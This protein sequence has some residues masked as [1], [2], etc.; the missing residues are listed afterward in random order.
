M[1]I[2][3]CWSLSEI[4]STLTPFI[5]RALNILRANAWR[6]PRLNL[7][8]DEFG[9]SVPPGFFV[10]LIQTPNGTSPHVQNKLTMPADG[11]KPE[12]AAQRF[13]ASRNSPAYLIASQSCDEDDTLIMFAN[14]PW[15]AEHKAT[16]AFCGNSRSIMLASILAVRSWAA[17]AALSAAPALAFSSAVSWSVLP[18]SSAFFVRNCPLIRAISM[19]TASSPNTPSVIKIEAINPNARSNL[20]GLPAGRMIPR[21]H[22]AMLWLYS[23]AT[24][25]ISAAT[26][27]T[28]KPVNHGS[29][30]S[31]NPDDLSKAVTALSRADMALSNAEASLGRAEAMQI[32]CEEITVVALLCLLGVR[33]GLLIVTFRRYK[34]KI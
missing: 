23:R 25:Q 17:A 31:Q 15:I 2:R 14:G 27:T 22:A 8:S 28:T 18:R 19:P 21:L 11:C 1:S 6:L 20:K 30:R 16:L 4:P 33:I 24:T 32:K 10:Y 34:G 7:K 26:P 3:P 29:N 12:A 5:C 9:R 13:T